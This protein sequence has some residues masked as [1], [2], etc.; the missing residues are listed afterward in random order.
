MLRPTLL[1][2]LITSF[3]ISCSKSD[4]EIVNIV[5]KGPRK[6][7]IHITES[8]NGD[9]DQNFQDALNAGMDVV[10]LTFYWTTLENDQGYDFELLDIMNAYFPYF[11]VP[12]SLNIS[13]VAAI[14]KDIPADLQTRKFND[15]VLIDRFLQLLDSIHQRIPAV[16]INNLLLGNEVDLY[17][18]QDPAYWPEFKV[19]Y[20]SA[21][22]KAKKLWGNQLRV[23][24][25]ITLGSLTQIQVD[26]ARQLN[27]HSDLVAFTYYP[28][29]S[30]FTMQPP[31]VV[32]D[33][34]QKVVDL[35]PDRLLFLEECGYASSPV[36]N[37][38]VEAQQEF[39]ENIFK[40]WDQYPYQLLYVGFLWLNDLPQSSVDFFVNDY[41]MH[42]QNHQQAFAAYLKTCGLRNYD[43]TA[44]PA[45][46]MLQ[47]NAH[48]RGW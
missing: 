43:G 48:L 16:K 10:P 39:V 34:L 21:L 7:G 26:P 13:P 18:N 30:D 27:Q 32:F 28:L 5:T 4:P 24:V 44:K 3:F 15:P 6:L 20:D 46:E 31:Q 1:L 23:G 11:D 40:F 47:I 19:F 29:E 22:F 33:D 2:L 38:S 14:D 36:C 42:G 9:Y 25:E 37:A 12:V 17:L 45:F 35:Y 41:G 8:K